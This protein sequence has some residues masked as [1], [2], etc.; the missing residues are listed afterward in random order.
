M[1][2]TAVP[3]APGAGLADDR[4]ATVVLIARIRLAAI[5]LSA[6][7][8]V[9][10]R[11]VPI[12]PPA[13]FALTALMTIYNVPAL[14]VRRL[15]RA[16][17]E[18]L[19]LTVLGGDFL[20][21]S[22]WVLLTGNDTGAGNYVTFMLVAA[23]LAVMYR[24]RGAIAFSA[25]FLAAF[26]SLY[27][28]RAAV[29]HFGFSVPSF[30]YRATMV[31]VMGALFGA[32]S[33]MSHRH[34]LA[35]EAAAL[36]A[37]TA[38]A[39]ARRHSDR[40]AALYR[41]AERIGGTLDGDKVFQSSVDA[42]IELFPL[43][44]HGI[45]LA[46]GERTLRLACC[47]GTPRDLQLTIPVVPSLAG[48]ET[49]VV[50]DLWHDP[51][52][53]AVVAALPAALRE[54]TSAAVAALRS[55]D[56]F[57]GILVSLDTA[58]GA[59]ADDELQFLAAVAHQ[60]SGGLDN[61]RLYAEIQAISLTDSLTGLANRRAF[62]RRLDDE[63]ARAARY[64][65]PLSVL[66]FDIDHFKSYNDIHGH[67]A[68]DGI[69][70]RIAEVL[71]G[72]VLRET[73]LA[74][75][76]GGDEFAIIM[77]ATAADQALIV[78]QRLCERVRAEAFPHGTLQPGGRVTVSVGVAGTP[79]AAATSQQVVDGADLA[80]YAAKEAGRDRASLY[81]P[82]LAGS[83][84][85][86][87]SLV[88]QLLEARTMDVV[89]QPIVRL[90][91]GEVAG[92]EALARPPGGECE[93]SVEGMFRAAQRLGVLLDLDWLCRRAAL[94]GADRIARDVPVFINISAG[95]LLDPDAD[96][97]GLALL[98][99]AHGRLPGDIVLEISERESIR[100][101]SQF[102][103]ALRHYRSAGFRF[104]LDDVGEGYSTI[105]VLAAADPE[106][107]K[108]AA[109]LTV[110]AA[111]GGPASAIRALVEFARSSGAQVI[112]E[113]I[114]EGQD[115]TVRALGVEFGQGFALGRPMRIGGEPVGA[116]AAS[117]SPVTP[118]ARSAPRRSHTCGRRVW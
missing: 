63:L 30:L 56:R 66:M 32:V 18:P 87:T 76:H 93:L 71:A 29:F 69:L 99:R 118:R 72:D 50:D 11:P 95:A 62:D 79:H 37:T 108:I 97:E 100:D 106:Y 88:P 75:R 73:D 68:G 15:P 47:R 20:V 114:A 27:W 13:L 78:G 39:A 54:Y 96:A 67:P 103:T 101:M 61:A 64:R 31:L 102:R 74:F 25:A 28:E 83:L 51:G 8:A 6:V 3:A 65:T 117:H 80:L 59:F 90:A 12:S 46:A 43:R 81:T 49:F 2:L 94:A 52:L 53:E 10:T 85:N 42:L 5:V 98:A 16:A 82:S 9:L 107:I 26:G 33:A 4:A 92:Y 24:W 58:A 48:S 115:V 109:G 1:T 110:A 113:G 104:A 21:C 7:M 40:S 34:R 70:A 111:S 23:E 19:V 105:E 55:R 41:V 35:A 17:L 22:G 91:T 38:A 77:P 57:L 45:L 36:H 89:F 112:A 60:V 14:L 84:P 44:W 116:A 86:W